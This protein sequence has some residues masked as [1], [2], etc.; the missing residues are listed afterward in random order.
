MI[1]AVIAR[2]SRTPTRAADRARI[3]DTRGS[4]GTRIAGS[5]TPSPD[6]V[7]RTADRR[8][9]S[10]TSRIANA[11]REHPRITAQIAD[12][13]PGIVETRTYRRGPRTRTADRGHPRIGSRGSRTPTRIAHRYDRGRRSRT[14]TRIAHRYR[15][16]TGPQTPP[17]SARVSFFLHIEGPYSY[18]TLS[19]RRTRAPERTCM[20]AP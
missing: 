11:D 12:T 5:R 16:A 18:S 3:A 10:R 2:G 9:G 7:P 17:R 4:D 20:L 15:T 19:K 8:R 14:P 6:R 13:H 1:V